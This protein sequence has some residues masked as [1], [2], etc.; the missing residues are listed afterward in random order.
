MEVTFDGNL[1]KHIASLMWD[2]K[3]QAEVELLVNKYGHPAEV[4][5]ELMIASHYDSFNETDIAA[6]ILAKFKRK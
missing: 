4:V 6:D 5:K 3:T 2:A 1:Y